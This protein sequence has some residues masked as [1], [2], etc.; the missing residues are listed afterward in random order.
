MPHRDNQGVFDHLSIANVTKNSVEATACLDVID[1]AICHGTE[2]W[3]SLRGLAQAI[4]G[5]FAQRTRHPVKTGEQDHALPS[6]VDAWIKT[7]EVGSV[8]ADHGDTPEGPIGVV[9]AT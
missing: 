3:R 7:H 1:T 4:R 8:Y 2:N 5:P 6:D 9:D